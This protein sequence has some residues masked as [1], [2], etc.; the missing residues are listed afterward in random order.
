MSAIMHTQ[1]PGSEWQTRLQH[2]EAGGECCGV[3]G[4]GEK[5]VEIGPLWVTGQQTL[6]PAHCSLVRARLWALAT[7]AARQ[8]GPWT[9]GTI[10]HTRPREPRNHPCVSLAHLQDS[11]PIWVPQLPPGAGEGGEGLWPQ[12]AWKLSC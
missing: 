4:V 10:T 3:S 9:P 1:G 6:G 8:R 11:G 7:L 2:T 12:Q 5:G